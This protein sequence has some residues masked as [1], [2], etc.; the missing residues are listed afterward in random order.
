[1]LTSEGFWIIDTNPAPKSNLIHGQTT[2][3]TWQTSLISGTGSI[4]YQSPELRQFAGN[5]PFQIST[6]FY[7]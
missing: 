3:I 5:L 6:Y 1:M 4:N 7:N 2:E